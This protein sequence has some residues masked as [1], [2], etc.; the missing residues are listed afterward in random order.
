MQQLKE[1]KKKLLSVV[2]HGEILIIVPPFISIHNML[3]GPHILQALARENGYKTDILYL[4]M[5]LASV[6]GSD[7]HEKIYS[8]PLF[9]MLGDRL[10]SGSAY[11]LPPLGKNPEFCA[12]QAMC[13]NG[14]KKHVK[15]IYEPCHFDT[16]IYLKTEQICKSFIDEVVS[17]ITSLD[18]KIVGC[19]AAI[20]GQTNCSIALLSGVKR[21]SSKTLTI[22]GGANCDGEMA[23]GIASLSSDID[24][25]FSGESE[26]AFLDF[27]NQ[28]SHGELPVQRIITG[29]PLKDLDSLPLPDYEIFFNQ[30]EYFLGEKNLEKIKIWYETSRGCRKIQKSKCTFCGV[31]QI[32]YRKKSISMILNDLDR[33]R[34]SYPNKM[35]CMVD[36]MMPGSY[37]R[38]LLPVISEKN[39]FPSLYY[40]LRAN[41]GLH[42]LISLKKAKIDTVLAG[43][44]SFSTDLLKLMNKGITGRQ[45]LLF[46]RNATSIGITTDWFLLWGFPGDKVS[47]YEEVLNIL[48]LIRHLQPPKAF[49]PL[50]ISRF[51]RYF[52]NQQYYKISRL[53]PWAA[54]KMVYP[55]WAE[56]DKLA[57]WHIADYPCEAMDNP[58]LIHEISG[59]LELWRKSWKNSRLTIV[60]FTD[61]Y[62][63][64]DSR[65]ITGKSRNHILDASQAKEIMTYCIYDESEYKKWAVEQKLGLVADSFYVPLVTASPEVLLEFEEKHEE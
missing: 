13:L 53:R 7:L 42:D 9:W 30:Y 6:I 3:L 62:F 33:I 11:G 40:Q 44:E 26:T 1:I 27:L 61:F 31:P 37:R 38:D 39:G 4:N 58:K 32:S 36:N 23:E 54:Y 8:A 2:K 49:W 25:V 28:Y 60:P 51:S 43:L 12:D 57:Y 55:D 19:A 35:I 24:Y 46:L 34:T 5:L 64:H 14:S 21:Q 48:P 47:Y 22:I 15:M 16:D 20:M 29:M 45:A 63:I 52:E 10:F 41:L 17:V 56:T 65:N 59:E 18:Y 50:I